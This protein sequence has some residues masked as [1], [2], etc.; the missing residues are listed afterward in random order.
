MTNERLVAIALLSSYASELSL[1]FPAH[2]TVWSVSEHVGG[3]YP[4]CSYSLNVYSETL[5]AANPLPELTTLVSW[6]ATS[7]A[8]VATMR[9]RID[10]WLAVGLALA[11]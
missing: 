9:S 1:R 3:M 11:A 4:T 10:A 2:K 6:Y 7:D 8:E 5:V